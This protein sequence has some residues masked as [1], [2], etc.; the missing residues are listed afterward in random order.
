MRE[1]SKIARERGGKEKKKTIE[2]SERRKG[3]GRR[4]E[5]GNKIEKLGGEAK[6]KEGLRNRAGRERDEQNER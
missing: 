4:E 5:R 3:K 6:G 2:R 1:M